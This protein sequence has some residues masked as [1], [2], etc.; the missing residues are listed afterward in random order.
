[1]AESV[2]G[3]AFDLHLFRKIMRYVKPY[4]KV[5]YGSI[6][7]TVVLSVLAAARPLIIQYCIDNFVMEPNLDGLLHYTLLLIGLLI[8][9]SGVQFL[10]IYAANY[11]GQNVVRD[12]RNQI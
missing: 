6:V 1:M 10:F 5:F 12:I 2:S 4:K 7:F 3:K 8:A 9:E 11:L